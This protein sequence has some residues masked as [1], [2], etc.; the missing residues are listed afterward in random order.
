MAGLSRLKRRNTLGA[1][2][3]PEEASRNL[4][5]PEVAPADAPAH[6]AVP[7]APPVAAN[8]PSRA[9]QGAR[10]DGRG[11][12][13]TGRTVQFATR[14]SMDFDDRL[15]RTAQREGLMLCEV[16]ERALDKYLG[17]S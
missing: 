11:L 7:P 5:A 1:P 14:V 16:L 15:R 13:K 12:R 6:H 2:P 8:V 3:S 17:D 4:A 9:G 10:I